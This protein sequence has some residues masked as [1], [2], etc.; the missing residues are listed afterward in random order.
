MSDQIDKLKTGMGV[1][2]AVL[3]HD[4]HHQEM[5]GVHQTGK[6]ANCAPEIRILT[7]FCAPGIRFC[8]PRFRIF[9]LCFFIIIF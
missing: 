7:N 6:F 1:K 4:G 9:A 8:A 2:A 3:R 5:K